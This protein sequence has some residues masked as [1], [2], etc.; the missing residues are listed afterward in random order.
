MT[1]FFALQDKKIAEVKSKLA[2]HDKEIKDITGKKNTQQSDIDRLIAELESKLQPRAL[3][4][5]V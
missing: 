1:I 3:P 5:A 4:L 2:N